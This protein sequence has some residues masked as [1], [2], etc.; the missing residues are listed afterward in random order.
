MTSTTSL[1]SFEQLSALADRVSIAPTIPAKFRQD[2]QTK[3]LLEPAQVAGNVLAVA[4]AGQELGLPPMQS[5]QLYNIIE[6]TPTLSARGMTAIIR[7]AGHKLE[8]T[9]Y[10]RDGCTI[11]GTRGD[12]GET[13]TV[14]H[15]EKD[16]VNA[17]L[18]L[19]TRK[20][21]ASVWAKYKRQMHHWRAVSEIAGLLFTDVLLGAAYTPEEQASIADV[22]LGD[23]GVI[24]VAQADEASG[25]VSADV[26]SAD[27]DHELAIGAL[28]VWAREND[29]DTWDDVLAA[30]QTA[31]DHEGG[32]IPESA[33]E[34]PQCDVGVLEVAYRLL[35][36][37]DT[38]PPESDVEASEEAEPPS[39]APMG[40]DD[41][42][43]PF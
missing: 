36:G 32:I 2:P 42:E 19:K 1:L 21:Y 14:S 22:D 33:G 16:R 24:A 4:M 41:P 40:E 12:T 37:T 43:R 15:T 13:M 27:D 3:R 8:V 35:T 11:V 30:V 28:R 20:G 26:L 38:E 39:D 17:G 10:D 31:A 25:I 34:I 7:R 9:R 23:E 18:S 29:N 6:G 5:L